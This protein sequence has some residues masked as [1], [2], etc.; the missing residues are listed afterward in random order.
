MQ[1][2]TQLS[3]N[4]AFK[5]ENPAY[6]KEQIIT[7]I[8]NKRSLLGFIEKAIVE[9][10][11][12]NPKLNQTFADVFAGTG[13][14]SRMA[15]QHFNKL[16]INDLEAYSTLTNR[17]FHTNKASLDEHEY[18]EELTELQNRINESPRTGI[19]TELYSP[20]DEANIQKD[21]RVFYTRRNAMYIDT[22]RQIIGEQQYKYSNLFLASLI[23]KASVHTNTSGVFKG[24]YKNNEGVGQF[25]GASRNALTRIMAE[26]HIE[27][28]ILSEFECKTSVS[29][30]DAI[31]FAKNCEA[32]DIAYLDPPYNQHPYGANY[33]ML[34]TILN[35]EQ[36]EEISPVSGIPKGWNRSPYNKRQLA[37]DALFETMRSINAKVILLSYNSEGFIPIGELIEEASTL[38]SVMSFDEKYNTFRGCRNLKDRSTHVTEH[39]I[40]IQRD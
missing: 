9:A 39:L 26:I 25:G 36:P 6:L 22:A 35:Y 14:V 10:Q 13:I 2:P 19:I 31:A 8:G 5:V 30:L 7:Y 12:Q 33:F 23:Q 1:A 3:L 38:G 18:Y 16:L 28:L 32:T 37:K 29:Q 34:N 40:M 21:D 15:R 4:N 11:R 20:K 17:A 27:P 24:F